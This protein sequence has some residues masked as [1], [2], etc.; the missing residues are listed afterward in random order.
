MTIT[1]PQCGTAYPVADVTA[2]AG[3]KVRCRECRNVWRVDAP[4]SAESAGPAVNGAENGLSNILAEASHSQ[5]T[6][7]LTATASP[8]SADPEVR[9][10]TLAQSGVLTG[11]TTPAETAG[12]REKS[13]AAAHAAAE[14]GWPEWP[15]D[16]DVP[17]TIGRRSLTPPSS[18]ASDLSSAPRLQQQ[19]AAAA[20][21]HD[22]SSPMSASIERRRQARLRSGFDEVEAAIT[23]VRTAPA[24]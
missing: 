2:V 17:V 12:R 1:C 13:T 20:P 19:S 15:A 22:A 8:A 6:A 14:F 24:A 4:Q 18:E 5:Q 21:A 16:S 3:R 23:A 11:Q 9:G 7:G 10:T